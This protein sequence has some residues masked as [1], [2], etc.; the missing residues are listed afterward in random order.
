M[1]TTAVA[2]RDAVTDV[3]VTLASDDF[4][5]KLAAALPPGMTV[6]RFVRVA[7]TAVQLAPDVV[8]K[9]T[10]GSVL[11]ALIRCAQDGLLPDNREAALALFGNQAVYLPMIGGFRKKAAEHNFSLTAQVIHERDGFDYELGLEQTLRHKP[12]PLGTD[13]GEPI[14]A[15][16]VARHPQHGVFVE[17]MGRDEIERVRAASRAK[18]SGPWAQWWGEMARKTVARRLFKQLPLGALDDRARGMLEAD[19]RSYE[20]S[21]GPLSDLPEVDPTEDEVLTGEVVDE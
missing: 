13:R 11:T 9:G 5:G 7:T 17:V 18:G 6:D 3:C 20:P 10:K 2:K 19:D 12:A 16:A 15:Y 21:L 8:T 4:K 14:G 1:S